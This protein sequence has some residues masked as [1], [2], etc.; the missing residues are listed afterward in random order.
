MAGGALEVVRVLPDV[1]AQD[2]DAGHLHQRLLQR[3]VLR[4][5]HATSGSARG[6]SRTTSVPCLALQPA[7]LPGTL[8]GCPM[9]PGGLR[10]TWLGVDVTASLPPSCTTSHAQPLP[11]RDVAAALNLSLKASMEPNASSMPA[12]R[13]EE[14]PLESV[15][16]VMTFQN[17][18]WL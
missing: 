7:R 8:C 11:K 9:V 2:G 3:V 5:H 13:P 10:R 17:R 1:Q 16:P 14:G 12:F 15:G 18:E 6:S 4:S